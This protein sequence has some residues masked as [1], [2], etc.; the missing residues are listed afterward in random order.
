MAKKITTAKRRR[1]AEENGYHDSDDDIDDSP[2]LRSLQ[3]CTDKKYETQ[4]EFWDEEGPLKKKIGLSDATR[5]K[6]YLTLENYMYLERQ[7]WQEDGHEYKHEGYRVLISAKLKCH[8]YTPARLGEI[9]ESSVRSGTGKGLRYKDTTLL[10]AWKDSKPELRWG[11]KREFAKGMQDKASQRPTHIL[12]EDVPN[13]LLVVNPM[14]FMISI[15]LAAGAVKHYQTV[16]QLLAIK[17]PDDQSY[18]ILNWA[19]YVLEK[20]VFPEM[21]VDD[22]PNDKI[23][24]G[25]GFSSQL[26]ELSLQAGIQHPITVYSMR[27]E[28]LIQATGNSYSKDELTKFAAHTNRVTLQRDYLSSIT[29]VD[30][31]AC[32]LKLPTRSDFAEN[33][34]SM[35]VKRNPELFLSLPAKVQD[36]LRQT[37]DYKDIEGKISSISSQLKNIADEYSIREL[38]RQ[39]DQLFT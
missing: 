18:W 8:V 35:T 1:R 25:T 23:Q 2:V 22:S 20:P 7:L 24:T 33:F 13:Q 34:R 12:Y 6:H 28:S 11:M 16:K 39:R 3:P 36:D 9:S 27:R 21:S 31:Q 17:P 29:N 10:V 4:L 38:T 37:E 32:F 15:F 30:S 19:D 14:L 5:P 26:T